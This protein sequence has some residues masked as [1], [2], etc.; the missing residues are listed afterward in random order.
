MEFE[1]TEQMQ[2][3]YAEPRQFVLMKSPSWMAANVAIAATIPY[4]GD[5]EGELSLKEIPGKVGFAYMSIYRNELCLTFIAVFS[6]L[7]C[8]YPL[9]IV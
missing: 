4:F 2:M 1:S 3:V 8:S 6:R 5:E 7:C 9:S